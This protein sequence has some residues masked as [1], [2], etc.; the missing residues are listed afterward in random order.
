MSSSKDIAIDIIPLE[1]SQQG[2]AS[3]S[4]AFS[5]GNSLTAD[6]EGAIR[7]EPFRRRGAY[8][9]LSGGE[10]DEHE[11]EE[12]PPSKLQAW[13]HRMTKSIILRRFLLYYLPPALILLI[14]TLVL[15]TV[16]KD[17]HIGDVHT[18]G[19]F[20]WLE[21]VWA[22]F[23]AA[24]ALAFVLPFVFQYFAGFISS[25]AK[26]YTDILKAVKVPMTA[27]YF[28]LLSRAATVLLCVFDHEKPGQCDDKWVL[29][30]RQVLLATIACTGF[31]FIEKVLIHL[32]TINYRKRQFKVRVEE[33]K[34]TIHIL[35]LMYEAS[36]K[37]YPGFCSRFAS[38][39]SKIHRSQTLTAAGEGG[40][41]QSRLQKRISKFYG[42]E[43]MAETK[44][45]LH[46]KE[47]LKV[48]SPR[49]V[50]LRAL[51]REDA[52]E[53]LARRLWL[54]FTAESDTVT[55]AD[56]ARILGPDRE[57]DA[58]DIFHALD[59]DENGDISLEEMTLLLTQF[60]RDR[61]SIERSMHDIGQ[62]VKSL[63]RI[64]EIFLCFVSILLYSKSSTPFLSK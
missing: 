39:D 16:A 38:E 37:M 31:F 43:A 11:D 62:A 23:W 63:D 21:V 42:A 2:H 20:V 50:V 40:L 51:E 61:T 5:R 24:W 53:A 35:A 60:C 59:K 8:A 10:N 56:I 33:S 3:R 49:S 7:Y 64:M 57:D 34:R 46:G 13:V 19:L 15:A 9:E 27:F 29:I 52:S 55:E 12:G 44:A 58:L 1:E 4:S 14:V 25:G 36:V 22:I 28:A 32:L 54:S 41:R 48:G 47:V 6:T 45:R 30:I 18:V 17:S 26:Y